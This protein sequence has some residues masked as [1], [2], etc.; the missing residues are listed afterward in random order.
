MNSNIIGYLLAGLTS[1]LFTIYI[2]PRK[3]SKQ[4]PI[5][6]TMFMGLGFSIVSIIMYIIF[7]VINPISS[8]TLIHPMLGLSFINGVFWTIACI[9]F[10]TSIDKIGVSRSA[11]WK[12][13]QGPIGSILILIFFSEFLTTKLIY[14]I[15]AIIIIFISAMI[16]T[17]KSDNE[18]VVDKKGIIY[19]IIAAI[20]FGI[21]AFLRKY[22][23]NAGLIYS[24]QVYLS[25]S[26]FA[27][28]IIY[29]LI[30]EKNLKELIRIKDKNNYL[31]II[32]GAIYCVASYSF[33]LAYKY[34]QGSIVFTIVQLNAVWT[35][36]VGI[37]FFKEINFRKN[38][39][40]IITGIIFTIIGVILLLLSQK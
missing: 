2:I 19:L 10:V 25:V 29:I 35:I 12:N 8:E 26:V 3:F 36:L 27:C 40:R 24:Q 32:A 34:T 21:N 33:L 17:I 30:K 37:F 7:K 16:L 5:Y 18:K 39:L 11:Q 22:V 13:L 4:K 1:L 28:S 15:L 38:W 14:L 20:F 23:T 31:G 6:Y 9:L